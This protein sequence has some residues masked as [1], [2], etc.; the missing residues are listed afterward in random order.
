MSKNK[1]DIG[2]N[3]ALKGKTL[4]SIMPQSLSAKLLF[5]PARIIINT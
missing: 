5:G 1:P 2:D 4:K 3:L